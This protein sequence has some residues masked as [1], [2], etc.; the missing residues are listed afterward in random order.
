[1]YLYASYSNSIDN[2]TSSLGITSLN[3]S[4]DLMVFSVNS[5]I[6]LNSS[7]FIDREELDNKV[8]AIVLSEI[9]IG[10]KELAK[11]KGIKLYKVKSGMKISEAIKEVFS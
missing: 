9:E 3:A 8:N 5:L 2:L 4:V 11:E 6:N 10:V 7:T 1:M